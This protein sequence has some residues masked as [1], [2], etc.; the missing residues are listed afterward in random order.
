MNCDN[1]DRLQSW[2]VNFGYVEDGTKKNALVKLRLCPSCSDKLNYKRGLAK[3]LVDKGVKPER[4]IEEETVK[5][6]STAGTFAPISM[7]L[8]LTKT[9]KS[10]KL[11][12]NRTTCGRAVLWSQL[13]RRRWMK[14]SKTIFQTC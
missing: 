10:R 12:S 13:R 7:I 3:K 14:S 2:E 8:P 4:E 11:K 9:Q 6:D 5:S 1:K